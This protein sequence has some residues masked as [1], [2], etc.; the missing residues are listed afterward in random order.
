MKYPLK[1]IKIWHLF[2][3]RWENFALCAVLRTFLAL[4]YSNFSEIMGLAKN[5]TRVWQKNL[6][7]SENLE[8][9]LP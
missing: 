1:V 7:F 5:L 2:N 4:S 3:V 8:Y 6:E 9:I